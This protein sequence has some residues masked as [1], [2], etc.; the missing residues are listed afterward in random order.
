M[1]V[2][3]GILF[4]ICILFVT[5]KWN[6]SLPFAKEKV[7]A[8]AE[9]ASGTSKK[10]DYGTEIDEIHNLIQACSQLSKQ[11]WQRLEELI[12]QTQNSF[13]SKVRR[14][15]PSLTE[16]DIHIILLTRLGLTHQ[17]IALSNNILLSSLR[18]RR[19][20]LKK[21]MKVKCDSLSN[22]IRELYRE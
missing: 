19:N 13:V 22:F 12:N 7:K 14:D 9:F 3:Y 10:I 20:R 1:G 18:T 21:K 16:N 5:H 2:I 4:I 17:E 8:T 15:Y 11:D 6:I